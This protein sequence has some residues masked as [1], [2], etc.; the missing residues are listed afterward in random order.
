MRRV[1]MTTAALGA[2]GAL[3][4][5]GSGGGGYTGGPRQ[6]VTVAE[7]WALMAP[8]TSAMEAARAAKPTGTGF[9]AALYEGYMEHAE[10]EFG[11]FNQDYKDAIYHANKALAAAR[12]T[13]PAPSNLS[14]RIEPQDKVAELTSAHS[15]LMAALPQGQT[16][17]AVA[18]GKAQSYFDCWAE[19]QEENFQPRDIDYCRNGF[20]ANLEKIEQTRPTVP[21]SMTPSTDVFFDFD[22]STLKNEYTPELDQLAQTMV[23]DTTAQ[24]LVWGFTDTAGTQRYNQ[25]LSE[26]RANAVARYL[27]RRGVTRNRLT[28]QGFGEENLAVDTPDNTPEARNRRVEIRRR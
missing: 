23:S 4:A 8:A 28:I 20:F 9:N 2:L 18:A 17:D 12:G 24:V 25:G 5:C 13:T 6:F 14:D 19:Q 7:N 21:E 15:R 16:A 10:Y 3:S 22:K 11:D 26:R 27:E 1:L